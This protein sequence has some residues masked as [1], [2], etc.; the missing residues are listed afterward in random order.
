MNEELKGII[1]NGNYKFYRYTAEGIDREA[2]VANFE[3]EKYLK[4]T[5]LRINGFKQGI[6]FTHHYST[7]FNLSKAGNIK[8]G[9]KTLQFEAPL[10]Y[11]D[12][13]RIAVIRLS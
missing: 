4:H 13:N 9:A 7:R 2:D 1:E 10:F 11:K 12:E 5:I 8:Q 3:F 6:L